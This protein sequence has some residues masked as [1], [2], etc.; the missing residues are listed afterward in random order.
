VS[1]TQPTDQILIDLAKA[2]DRKALEALLERY[3]GSI[4]RFGIK[5]CRDPEA[6]K[7][8]LQ[9][10]LIA[11]TRTLSGFRGGSAVSTWLYTIAR[12][13]CIKRHRRGKFDP[14]V[15][16]SIDGSPVMEARA[17]PDHKL[18]PEDQ[19]AGQQVSQIL[20]EAISQLA[21]MYRE[22]LLLRDVEGLSAPEVGEVLGL[23]V[24]AVKSRLHRARL[25]VREKVAPALGV[26]VEPARPGCPDVVSLLSR[27]LE[28]ELRPETCEEMERHLKTCPHCTSAC[29]SLKKTLALCRTTPTTVV[30]KDVQESV[31]AALAKVLA[32]SS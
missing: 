24:E 13:F 4:W 27:H 2:G 5:M 3:Q 10:T 14:E 17:V 26:A 1:S 21:P 8:I 18:G 6:A 15:I 31:R 20:E 19:V 22:V 12:S 32:G 29:D 28:G 23:S 16:E 25:A 30:P 9:E 7:E 11:A